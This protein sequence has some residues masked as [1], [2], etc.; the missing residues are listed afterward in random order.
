M[1]LNSPSNPAGVIYSKQELADI[2]EVCLSANIIIISDEIYEK[3]IYDGNEHYS[4]ASLSDEVKSNTIV[5]NGVSKSFSMTG[6][7]IGYMAANKQIIDMVSTLQSHATSNPCSVSQDAAECALVSDLSDI[8]IKNSMEFSSR[9]DV[10][11]KKIL[12]ETSL[13]PFIPGGA[14]YLFC[15]ISASGLNSLDFS[16][17]LLEDK[18]V[19]VVPGGPFGHDDYIRISFATDLNTLNEGVNRMSDWLKT[20]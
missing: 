13:I 12:Q 8:L 18:K 20:I 10:L 19:A 15:N 2:A 16:Q 1:I 14:F 11:V 7:R 4:I 9:R 17:R 5:I 3:I 6:W